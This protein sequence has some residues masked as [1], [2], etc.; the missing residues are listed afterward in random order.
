MSRDRFIDPRTGDYVETLRPQTRWDQFDTDWDGGLTQWDNGLT[1]WDAET[2]WDDGDTVWDVEP[3]GPLRSTSVETRLYL[4]LATPLGSFALDPSLGSRTAN[5][6]QLQ[7]SQSQQVIRQ[8]VLDALRRD[9]D[10]ERILDVEVRVTFPAR[11]RANIEV[12]CIDGL[13]GQPVVISLDR[14][15]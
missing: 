6:R 13:T 15:L 3:A 11:G 5:P 8:H 12:D 7:Q 1:S 9:I 2:I 14:T 4:A 10:S